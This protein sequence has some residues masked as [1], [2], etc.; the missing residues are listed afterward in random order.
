[1]AIDNT[2][3]PLDGNKDTSYMITSQIAPLANQTMARTRAG[4]S[5][6]RGAIS[7]RGKRIVI[8][9][10]ACRPTLWP[11]R[12]PTLRAQGARR[13]ELEVDCSSASKKCV[14]C[15]HLSAISLH[16]TVLNTLRTGDAD[17]RFYITTVQD[18]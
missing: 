7:A 11:I 12:P 16:V 4:R 9:S 15:Y 5:S 13:P 6:N 17:L 2:S 8:V 18:G 10:K 14:G 1:M 3:L